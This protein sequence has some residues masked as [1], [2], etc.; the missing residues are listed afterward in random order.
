MSDTPYAAMRADMAA[1]DAG[2]TVVS[3]ALAR[4]I[5]LAGTCSGSARA[6]YGLTY[7][8]DIA[9]TIYSIRY[10]KSGTPQCRKGEPA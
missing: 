1:L 8:Y 4:M 6:R 5:K 9:G 2:Q 10:D 7:I 3:Y